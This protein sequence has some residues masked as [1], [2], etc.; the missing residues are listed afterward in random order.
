M[1]DMLEVE[2]RFATTTTVGLLTA[3]WIFFWRGAKLELLLGNGD[4]FIQFLPTWTWAAAQWKALTPPL[5]TPYL[6][7]GFPL[8][9]DPTAIV[10]HPALLLFMLLPPVTALNLTV[11]LSFAVAGV[12]TF[13]L[14]RQEGLSVEAALLGGLTFAFS[15]FLLGHE[16]I[17]PLLMTAASF[18]LVFCAL[19]RLRRRPG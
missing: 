10:F 7:A 18:P 13:V 19:R 12:F 6:Y 4:A 3:P 8:F 2:K 14:A 5:W 17:T 16:G 1:R 15:G 9:A 11:L